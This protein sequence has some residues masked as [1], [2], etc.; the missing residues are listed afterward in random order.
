MVTV[1]RNSNKRRI[2]KFLVNLTKDLKKQHENIG[3][4][5][6]KDGT[7]ILNDEL[8]KTLQKMRKSANA[9]IWV[10]ANSGRTIGDM[11]EALNKVGVPQECFDFII[12]DNGGMAIDVRKKKELFK[13]SMEQHVV[14]QIIEGF[15][16]NGGNAKNIRLAN[17]SN[18]IA[19]NHRE[20]RRYYRKREN[21]LFIRDIRKAE[22]GDITK[23]TLT[24]SKQQIDEIIN[25]VAQNLPQYE[26]HQGKTSFPKEKYNNYRVDCTSKNNKGQAMEDMTRRLG[27][28]RCIV[29]GNDL[30]DLSMFEVALK[31][32]DHI[33]IAG[34][35]YPEITDELIKRLKE[36]CKAEKISWSKSNVLVLEEKNVNAFLQKVLM[37]VGAVNKGK[38]N[39]K[40]FMS[41]L[42]YK[43]ESTSANII[44]KTHETKTKTK[45]KKRER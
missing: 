39:R 24:G 13:H 35:E 32:G 2:S 12:G 18:I 8:F 3:I 11:I 37:V 40:N 29:L 36:F 38:N 23:I 14:E 5:T 22:K 15:S 1:K 27:L 44:L 17:G 28:D 30:N 43:Q 34:N 31:R 33:V 19:H 41:R 7:V 16:K 9:N 45:P 10:I 26:T 20:V 6:D 25:Y 4:I 42:K 21:V